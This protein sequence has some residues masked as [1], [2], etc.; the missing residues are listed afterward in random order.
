MPS[1]QL[2]LRALTR[3]ATINF[4]INNIPGK[5]KWAIQNSTHTPAMAQMQHGCKHSISFAVCTHWSRPAKLLFFRIG[6]Y[7]PV[8]VIPPS[9]V[10]CSTGCCPNWPLLSEWWAVV[11]NLAEFWAAGAKHQQRHTSAHNGHMYGTLDH[12]SK[13]RGRICHA[14]AESFL[15]ASWMVWRSPRRGNIP[16]LSICHAKKHEIPACCHLPHILHIYNCCLHQVTMGA[17]QFGV[18]TATLVPH[19]AAKQFNT[20]TLLE[21]DPCQ[22]SSEIC[23]KRQSFVTFQNYIC[24]TLCYAAYASGHSKLTL[25]RHASLWVVAT[26]DSLADIE[27]KLGLHLSRPTMYKVCMRLSIMKRDAF[28]RKANQSC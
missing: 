27:I 21:A 9:H 22:A 24:G 19:E 3:S 17:M 25:M 11:G 20:Y 2:S 1:K 7:C 8:L 12:R 14:A 23:Y 4:P 13:I 18:V 16:Q 26:L 5:Q 10:C 6:H 15:S 28:V